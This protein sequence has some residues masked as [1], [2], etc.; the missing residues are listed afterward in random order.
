YVVLG[1][2]RSA[3]ADELKAAYRK[4]SLK[5]HPDR[6]KGGEAARK[7]ATDKM[8]EINRAYDVL[9]DEKQRGWYD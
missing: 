6:V 9:K 8:A 7:A 3:T 2:S 5:N 1:M 4:L